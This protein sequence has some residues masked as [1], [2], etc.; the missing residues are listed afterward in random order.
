MNKDLKKR[1]MYN[2]LVS[3]IIPN[4]CHAKYLDQRIQSVLGQTY[5]NFE[6][7]ILDDC[8]PDN[9]ASQ[10]VIEK[11]RD[12]PHVSHII[13]NEQNSGSTF[14]QWNK[15]FDS[16]I[17]EYC[18]IAES[19][20]FC[21]NDLLGKLVEQ[22]QKYENVSIVA[23]NSQFVDENGKLLSPILKKDDTITLFKGIDFIRCKMMHG[24][25]IYNASSAIFKREYALQIDSQ[26]MNYVA[27]GDRLFWIELAEMGNVVF[28]SS[29]KNY[30]RQHQ[31]KVSPQK[32][33]N[34]T[35]SREDYKI[36]RYLEKKGYI[37]F[38][39]HFIVRDKYLTDIK[40]SEFDSEYIKRSLVRLWTYNGFMPQRLMRWLLNIYFKIKNKYID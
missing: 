31:N 18:W 3:V 28:L 22:T 17:G 40:S 6:V 19:D 9:S 26:Y 36:V 8:S 7:I 37:F 35:T 24:N 4:Y 30:F 5:Q 39:E 13:Y 27:A 25:G 32:Q 2:P 11:Y 14:K 23:C 21:D 1:K 29:P 10:L 16:A 12:D 20:D 33:R 15:G 34:G 38:S